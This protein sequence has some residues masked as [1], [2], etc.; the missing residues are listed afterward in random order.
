EA[1]IFPPARQHATDWW[2]AT[3][4]RD[5]HLETTEMPVNRY[6]PWNALL[7]Q[8]VQRRF[9][10]DLKAED[11]GRKTMHLGVLRGLN[12][13]GIL[14]ECGF[15]TSKAEAHKIGTTGYRQQIAKAIAD[16]VHDYA[17]T[18]KRHSAEM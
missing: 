4:K 3:A 15:L 7:A 18:L 17:S 14:V 5:S 16:G 11:R 8:A 13:P 1:Y 2:G 6:D 10:V 12:C 9:V